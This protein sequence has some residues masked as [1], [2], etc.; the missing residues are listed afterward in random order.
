MF[1][2]YLANEHVQDRRRRA[3][4]GA[5][6]QQALE[7]R[8]SSRKFNAALHWI[9][10]GSAGQILVVIGRWLQHYAEPQ[11]EPQPCPENA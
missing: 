9:L 5:L 1:N 2:E 8:K 10:L 7:E 3:E 4:Q 11:V 6:I